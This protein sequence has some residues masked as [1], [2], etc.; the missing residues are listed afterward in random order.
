MLRYYQNS[1]AAAL[2]DL[3]PEIGLQTHYFANTPRTPP[4]PAISPQNL[5]HNYA[6]GNY[7]ITNQVTFFNSVAQDMKFDPLIA[8]NWY[9]VS[10]MDLI[11]R[12]VQTVNF[13]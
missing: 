4:P 8:E 1:I 10:M 3:F 13:L 5:M 11:N 9:S 12:K 7:W 2:S 6:P